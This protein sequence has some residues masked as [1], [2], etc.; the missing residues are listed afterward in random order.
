MWLRF[1]DDEFSCSS[2][3]RRSCELEAVGVEGNRLGLEIRAVLENRVLLWVPNIAR[4][5]YTRILNRDHNF[6][7][8]PIH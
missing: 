3:Q 6:R 2:I 7:E 5:P 1:S 4:H 8:L